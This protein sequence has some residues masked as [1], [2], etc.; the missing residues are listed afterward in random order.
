MSVASLVYTVK[1]QMISYFAVVSDMSSVVIVY[2]ETAPIFTF[3]IEVNNRSR[4]ITTALR[5]DVQV[6]II[7]PTAPSNI[8]GVSFTYIGSLVTMEHWY[9]GGLI[10]RNGEL[11]TRGIYLRVGYRSQSKRKSSD[12]ANCR[13]FGYTFPFSDDYPTSD[14][15]LRARY[16][17]E[18]EL[19]RT[20]LN[21]DFCQSGRVEPV[22]RVPVRELFARIAALRDVRGIRDVMNYQD[23]SLICEWIRSRD[24]NITALDV[25]DMLTKLFAR[26]QFDDDSE[27]GGCELPSRRR[28][29][30]SI[31]TMRD[32]L[33]DT[34]VTVANRMKSR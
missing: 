18:A 25:I 10:I 27:F 13:L 9:S 30:I 19:N 1:V 34:N 5:Q 12:S 20:A 16:S 4:D 31:R 8:P 17:I 3:P 32:R 22:H 21:V 7:M 14:I 33:N 29:K 23:Y 28:R 15:T 26:G 11:H 6:P 24:E 2:R